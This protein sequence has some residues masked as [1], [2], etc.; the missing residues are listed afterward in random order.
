MRITLGNPEAA[1]GAK[2][3]GLWLLPFKIPLFYTILC[4]LLCERLGD[5]LVCLCAGLNYV[6]RFIP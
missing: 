6:H 4:L 5:L 1:A 2:S 3:T